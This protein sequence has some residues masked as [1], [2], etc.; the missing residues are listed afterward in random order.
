MTVREL[1]DVILPGG[2]RVALCE[3]GDPSGRVALYFHG[4]GSPRLETG[5]HASAAAAAGV[6]LVGWDRPGAGGSP[7]QPGRSLVD[8]VADTQAVVEH[9]GVDAVRVA[10][11]SGGGS[12][13]LALAA[14]GAPLV[15][16]AVAVNPGP[17][18]ED[19]LLAVLPG[20]ISRFMRLARDHPRPSPW[21][22][23]PCITA[24]RA[25]S[26]NCS[27]RADA[28]SAPDG[29]RSAPPTGRGTGLPRRR[30]RGRPAA[31]GIHQRGPDDLEPPVRLAAGRVPGSLRRV[32]RQG[33][34]VP[35]LRG[36]PGTGRGGTS[37]PAVTSPGS[38]PR[39]CGRSWRCSSDTSGDRISTCESVCMRWESVLEPNAQ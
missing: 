37:S 3:V 22:R 18:A 32:H 28:R 26:P 38:C 12:P 36:A 8:V 21:C 16:G 14:N 2:R 9:L 34:P 31:T 20:Q 24:A 29:R 27:S 39:S 15:H 17:P 5:L 25:R 10:G 19:D 23:R 1:D 6:R 35:S 30:A 7:A 13:V 11:I 33:R 4:T